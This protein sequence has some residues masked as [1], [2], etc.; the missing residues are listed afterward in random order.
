MIY[1][2]QLTDTS[3]TKFLENIDVFE[4]GPDF[5][6]CWKLFSKRAARFALSAG[7]A[8]PVRSPYLPLAYR[9]GS[10][11][12]V[13][14][15]VALSLPLPAFAA[16][17]VNV[18]A[19]EHTCSELT[20]IIRQNKRSSSASV[21]AAAVSVIRPPN[22]AWAISA[23]RPVCAMQVESSA[24][25]IMPAFSTPRRPITFPRRFR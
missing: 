23:P 13:I 10:M 7:L 9:E 19:S 20:Q 25:L 16:A 14:F 4:L 8:A 1:R 24:S 6:A 12:S 17:V 15:V 22:A 5:P 11:R 21:S 3:P 18:K 2:F